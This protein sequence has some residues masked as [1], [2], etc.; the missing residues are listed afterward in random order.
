MDVN[1]ANRGKRVER[2]YTIK[3]KPRETPERSKGHDTLHMMEG[4]KYCHCMCTRCFT[5]WNNISGAR[6][7]CIC[8]DCPCTKT[9]LRMPVRFL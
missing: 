5:K 6:G 1:F 7:F 4:L 8:P 2:E 3:L 9:G